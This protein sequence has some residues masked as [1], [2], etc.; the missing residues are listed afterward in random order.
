MDKKM[1]DVGLSKLQGFNFVKHT[2]CNLWQLSLNN[3]EQVAYV[4]NAVNTHDSLVAENDKY[5]RLFWSNLY[6]SKVE[7]LKLAGIENTKL[8]EKLGSAMGYLDKDICG[9][10]CMEEM[11]H[12]DKGSQFLWRAICCGRDLSLN[13]GATPKLTDHKEDCRYRKLREEI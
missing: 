12:E 11:F 1:K 2:R 10:K 8:K 5:R 13:D 4:K 6:E 7:G 3:Q 9:F